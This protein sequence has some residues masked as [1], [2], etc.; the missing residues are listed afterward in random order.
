M[1]VGKALWAHQKKKAIEIL[2]RDAESAR[3]Q[4]RATDLIQAYKRILAIDPNRTDIK[5]L[6]ARRLR[7][8][9]ENIL[10]IAGCVLGAAL[11]LVLGIGW[12]VST[13]R[14][15][16]GLKLVR[17]AEE[18]FLAG[19]VNAALAELQPMLAGDYDAEVE[20]KAKELYQTIE[21]RELAK[22]ES[23]REEEEQ[24]LDE[25]L[26]VVQSCLSEEKYD[27][28]LENI[29]RLLEDPPKRQPTL[30][31][32][33]LV[34]LKALQQTVT[35]RAA[36]VKHAASAYRPL[37]NDVE[38]LRGYPEVEAK[39]RTEA[40]PVLERLAGFSRA[41]LEKGLAD[42]AQTAV[43]DI[44][45]ASQTWKNNLDGMV[46]ELSRLKQQYDRLKTL[47]ELSDEFIAATQA[48][49]SGD[50]ETAIPL[51]EKLISSYGG[52]DLLAG[53]SSRLQR[54][55]EA[56]DVLLRIEK[57][58][59]ESSLEEAH[60]LAATAA[61]DYK[62]LKIDRRI[63][64]PVLLTTTPPG[65]TLTFKDQP[66]LRSPALMWVTPGESLEVK[67]NKESFEPV[68]LTLDNQHPRVEY[69]L[70][71]RVLASVDLEESIDCAPLYDARDDVLYAASRSGTLYRVQALTGKV[72]GLKKTGSLSG[73]TTTPLLTTAG[74]VFTVVEGRIWMVR[75]EDSLKVVWERDLKTEFRLSPIAS[76]SH[77]LVFPEAARVCALSLTDGSDAW[78]LD[79]SD[80]IT[81][82]PALVGKR[83]LLPVSKGRLR[84]LDV[85]SLEER[86]VCELGEEIHGSM[87]VGSG[88]LVATT[89]TGKVFVLSL[90]ELKVEWTF[91]SGELLR[92]DGSL[93]APFLDLSINDTLKRL[94]LEQ[95]TVAFEWKVDTTLSTTPVVLGDNLLVGGEDGFL[96]GF[97]AGES[98]PYFKT[99][100]GTARIVGAPVLTSNGI[101]VICANG[102]FQL[103]AR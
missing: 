94:D 59:R 99:E 7:S 84:V 57:L 34:N 18:V 87:L 45:E 78:T 21:A 14:T 49:D 88:R 74:I 72:L 67:V 97:V 2:L 69:R 46:G 75:P 52:G 22:L 17:K 92:C 71:R 81:A 65:A 9:G 55:Q 56:R 100:V 85:D 44:A 96:Y 28:A 10:R 25:K 23:E 93:S 91:D 79:L 38:I 63:R 29:L 47:E 68:E 60:E 41:A 6:L 66:A 30:R 26:A 86:R 37:Q 83:L 27:G 77:L 101:A 20:S 4:N 53:M 54:L 61:V 43:K 15:H 80:R 3:S 16:K 11:L 13:W 19:D 42:D 24:A 35:E 95:K 1:L 98:Q 33:I 103:L 12:I 89:V 58:A 90:P 50:L 32:R 36:S 40:G 76:T 70:Q 8:R 73:S 48:A 102:R 64:L 82:T 31:S 62:D 51:F 39:F 5:R